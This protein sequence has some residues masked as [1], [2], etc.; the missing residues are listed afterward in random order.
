[1]RTVTL[2]LL[3]SLSLA[4]NSDRLLTSSDDTLSGVTVSSQPDGSS[5]RWL[6][7]D[8]VA[9]TP[10]APPSQVV[11]RIGPDTPVYRRERDLSYTRLRAEAIGLGELVRVWHSGVEERTQTPILTA[12]QVVV[13]PGDG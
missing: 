6:L 2:A 13:L 4:C 9:T 3:G 1:M 8:V 12:R 11:I 10:T 5:I 7:T